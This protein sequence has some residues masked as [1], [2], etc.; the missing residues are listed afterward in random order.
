MVAVDR[1]EWREERLHG[2]A[3]LTL[4]LS[5][6]QNP[7]RIIVASVSLSFSSDLKRRTEMKRNLKQKPLQFLSFCPPLHIFIFRSFSLFLSFTHVHIS[8]FFSLSL[9]YVHLPLTQTLSHTTICSC[10]APRQP[11]I[12]PDP[13]PHG[14][15][16]QGSWSGSPEIPDRSKPAQ[17]ALRGGGEKTARARNS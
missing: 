12:S 17:K 7:R 10:S 13:N 6:L 14:S 15:V 1:M 4:C 9:L 11:P 16:A 5:L 8:L 2:L 3:T